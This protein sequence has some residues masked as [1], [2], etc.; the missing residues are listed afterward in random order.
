[1]YFDLHLHYKV[2]S[3]ATSVLSW[4]TETGPWNTD[5]PESV[6]ITEF[7]PKGDTDDQWWIANNN[8]FPKYYSPLG[9]DPDRLWDDFVKDINDPNYGDGWEISQFGSVGDF[10]MASLLNTIH[11]KP[12]AVV[13]YGPTIQGPNLADV[14][15]IAA[16]RASRLGS[17]QYIDDPDL[18]TK[19]RNNYQDAAGPYQIPSGLFTPHATACDEN[20]VYPPC[21]Q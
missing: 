4:L 7:S 14:F 8:Q 16:L 21:I 18:F 11:G 5:Y 6:V 19:V 15:A 9:D 13:C 17:S 1:M 20:M 3:D 2:V 10:S 12:Y